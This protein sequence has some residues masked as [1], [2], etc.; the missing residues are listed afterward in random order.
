M[1]QIESK[2]CLLESDK[3]EEEH[4]KQSKAQGKSHNVFRFTNL[5]QQVSM[6]LEK[7]HFMEQATC[8]MQMVGS[9]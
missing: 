2:A 5:L 7:D 9:S 3:E 4:G 8:Y 1:E 6:V